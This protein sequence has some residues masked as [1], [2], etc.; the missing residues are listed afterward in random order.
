MKIIQQPCKRTTGKIH[1]N[2]IHVI[3]HLQKVTWESNLPFPRL[4]V[5]LDST[6]VSSSLCKLSILVTGGMNFALHDDTRILHALFN[7][8]SQPSVRPFV[9]PSVRPSIHPYIHTYM[10]IHLHTHIQICMYTYI[11]NYIHTSMHIYIHTHI[12]TYIRTYT[13]THVYTRL[14]FFSVA[15]RPNAGHGLLILEVP[16]SHTTTHHSR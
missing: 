16:R 14:I 13:R 15:L 1:H 5:L 2:L 12:H 9:R 7:Y 4:A 6:G 11:H 3:L 10:P 8:C